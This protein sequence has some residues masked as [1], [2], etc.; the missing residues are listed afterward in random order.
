MALKCMQQAINIGAIHAQTRSIFRNNR[1]ADP[2]N[3]CKL[4]CMY[5]Q[6]RDSDSLMLLKVYQEWISKFHPYL[7]HKK[8]DEEQQRENQREQFQ[9]NRGDGK[10]VFIKRPLASERKWCHDRSLDINILR[11]V[12]TL[13]EEIRQRFMKMNISMTCLNS[14]VR[15]R[16]DNPDAELILKICIGGA[17][18]NKYIKAAYKNDD[19]L[20]RMK[21]SKHFDEET[22]KRSLILNKVSEHITENHLKQ[23]FEGKFKVPVTSISIISEKP[24]IVFSPMILEK[25]LMKACFKIGLRNRAS[26]YRKLQEQ[27]YEQKNQF[28]SSILSSGRQKAKNV[29]ISYDEAR[30]MLEME[31]LKRPNYLYELRFETINKESYVDFDCDSINNFT[32][33]TNPNNLSHI[34]Y[35]CQEYYDK[36]GRFLSRNGTKLP[37]VP[38]VDALYCLIFAPIVQVMAD[39]NKMY[40]NKIICDNGEL[41]LPLTH[42]LTHLDLE[43]A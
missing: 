11:E 41:V 18:Y 21:N 9:R 13:A 3:T 33:E 6:N 43:L 25:G 17:F 38:M 31:E 14:K 7:K 22:A 37:S 36:G 39:E 30:E 20:S 24:T 40:F 35:A 10:R 2:V 42:V 26:R 15:L 23:Y 1:G 16:D 32:Y 4:Q 34:T 29:V 28:V 8:E 19:I 12:A 27:E 5:D